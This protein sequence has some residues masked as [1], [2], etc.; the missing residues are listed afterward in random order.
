MALSWW[1]IA[2]I[3]FACLTIAVA[4]AVLL[5]M[6]QL[7]RQLRPLANTA[8][9]TRLPEYRRLARARTMSMIAVIT[10]LVVLFTAAIL[11]SARPTAWW[12]SSTASDAP[13]DIM[14][15]V[16]DPVTDPATAEF[17]G[18]FAA[19]VRT[20]GTQRI[21]VTSANRR[22]VPMTRDYQYAGEKLNDAAELAR[23]QTRSDLPSQQQSGV[24]NRVA[25]FSPDVTYVDYAASVDDVLALCMSG[26]PSFESTST[27]RRSLIYFGPGELRNPDESRPSLYTDQQITDMAAAGGIQLNAVASS[28]PGT[29]RAVIESTGGQYFSISARNRDM[30][31]DLDAIRSRPPAATQPAS[32]TAI[33]WLDDSPIVPLAV[34]VVVS[35]LLSL[36]LMVLRR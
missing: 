2:A 30:A 34:A 22:V 10:L 16:A 36:S 3:G 25:A 14:L 29:L 31:A 17:L 32:A 27:H 23:L 33:S 20:Y 35:M 1:P 5:P 15:C 4:M 7:R 21:G 9:L 24:R 19:Q 6:E 18:Y 26:F 28:T 11:A 8:R 12:W 13:E